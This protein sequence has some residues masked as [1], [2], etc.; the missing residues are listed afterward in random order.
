MTDNNRNEGQRGPGDKKKI[1]IT[2]MPLRGHVDPTI[3]IAKE[4]QVRG[5]EVVWYIAEKSKD[6]IVN[7]DITIYATEGSF[8]YVPLEYTLTHLY[9]CGMLRY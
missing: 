5:F 4:L 8:S 6:L 9:H 1:L 2:T 7:T 3:S